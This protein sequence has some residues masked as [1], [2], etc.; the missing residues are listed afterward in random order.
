MTIG[1]AVVVITLIV[2]VFF[3]GPRCWDYEWIHRGK[4]FRV[5]T[6]LGKVV[7]MWVVMNDCL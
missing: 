2:V 3:V 1:A 6:A 7:I 5:L 4:Y